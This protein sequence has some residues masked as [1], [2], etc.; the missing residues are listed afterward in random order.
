MSTRS[1]HDWFFDSARRVPDSTALVVGEQRRTYRQL[2]RFATQLSQ[3][4]HDELLH[5]QLGQASARVGLLASRSVAAYAGYLAILRAGAAVVPLNP[6]FPVTRNVDVAEQSGL[7][8]L[9]ADEAGAQTDFAQRAGLPMLVVGS[10]ESVRLIKPGERAADPRIGR[11]GDRSPTSDRETDGDRTAYIMFTSGSTGRPKG[12][13][14]KHRNVEAYLRYNIGRYG[15]SPGDRM[16]QTFDLTFD[17]SVFDLFACWGAGAT[18]FVPTREE[19][20]EPVRFIRRHRL[21]H[22]YSVPSLISI[23]HTLGDLQPGGLPHLRW[24]LFAGE[25]LTL[26]QAAAWAMAAP[27]GMVENVY[28]PTELTVTVAAY[29]LPRAARDWPV[30]SNGTVPIGTCYPHL[31]HVLLAE[32][33]QQAGS[34]ELCL[35]GPQRFDGYLDAADNEGRFLRMAHGMAAM[36]VSRPALHDW[37]RTGDNVCHTGGVLV[38]LGRLDNQVKIRGNRVELAEVEAALRAEDGVDRA[39]VVTLDDQ[40]GPRL[41]VAYTGVELPVDRLRA[42]LLGRLP[43]YMVPERYVHLSTLPT[44]TNG[45]VDR[46][47]VRTM[48]SRRHERDSRR[49]V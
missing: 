4:L 12:V 15:L 7:D 9:I 6:T 14:I 1:L 31:E 3:L 16:S 35:R 40:D 10:E 45:K 33:G 48:L 38:H 28:G 11:Y 8:A 30:T 23:S 24:S 22:W 27:A 18:L 44:N 41:A 2:G 26:D 46:H 21:T 29:R 5:N 19:L 20:Y 47:A 36:P 39:L 34:G 37:Y 49:N 25:Q 42:N 17:P 32:N 13:P 43:E